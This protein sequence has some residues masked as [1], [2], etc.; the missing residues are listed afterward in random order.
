MAGLLLL[1]V[2]CLSLVIVPVSGQDEVSCDAYQ[3]AEIC[4]INTSISESAVDRGGTVKLKFTARN[5]GNTTEDA[6]VLIGVKQPDG[7]YTYNQVETL[8]SVEPGQ[9]ITSSVRASFEDGTTG[10]H[11]L[12]FVLLDGPQEHMFDSTGY[13]TKLTVE[14]G[15][16]FDVVGAFKSLGIVAEAILLVAALVVGVLGGKWIWP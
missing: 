9:E 8:N 7:G 16:P 5:V 11:E 6:I 1:A 2:L 14:D 12:N 3:G 15:D 4:F 10:V 13:Y